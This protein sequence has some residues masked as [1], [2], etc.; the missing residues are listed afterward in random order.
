LKHVPEQ[1]FFGEIAAASAEQEYVQGTLRQDLYQK[2]QALPENDP[3]EGLT[4]LTTGG[5]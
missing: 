1:S 5:A 3:G 2:L 4:G